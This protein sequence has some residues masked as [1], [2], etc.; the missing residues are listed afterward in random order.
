[1]P[2]DKTATAK[3]IQEVLLPR[4]KSNGGGADKATSAAKK[5][6][7]L[8]LIKDKA[9]KGSSWHPKRGKSSAL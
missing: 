3:F 2:N 4:S 7:V 9:I 6:G 1:M 8:G 5:A